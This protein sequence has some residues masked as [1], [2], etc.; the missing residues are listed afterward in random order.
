MN[1]RQRK[2][3]V[4]WAAAVMAAGGIV[5]LAAGVLT[6]V[7]GPVKAAS[8]RPAGGREQPASA[9]VAAEAA[10][11]SGLTLDELQQLCS[12]DLR[13]P[14][15]ESAAATRPQESARP[16]LTLTV[17]VLGAIQEPGHSM[18]ILQKSDG[19]IDTYGEGQKFTDAGVEVTV[20]KVGREK[21]V[22]V[23]GG[24]TDELAVPREP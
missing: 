2:R 11:P 23:H 16:A 1:V 6:P 9:P 12:R 20:L 5:A 15:F 17:R 10:A 8:S 14:L 18:A 3:L 22:I 4:T 7:A 21:V 13:A 19:A 24:Q